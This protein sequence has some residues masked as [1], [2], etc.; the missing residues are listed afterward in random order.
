[1][2]AAFMVLLVV[3]RRYVVFGSPATIID[4]GG[5]IV[6]RPNVPIVVTSIMYDTTEQHCHRQ[7]Q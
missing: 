6:S 7:E 4:T 2:F 5:F 3:K 1:M